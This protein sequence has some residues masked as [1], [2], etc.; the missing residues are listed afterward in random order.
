MLYLNLENR[1][2]K[3]LNKLQKKQFEQV[4]GKIIAMQESPF[5]PDTK[6]IKGMDWYRVD[7]GEF[8]IIFNVHSGV[9]DVPLIGKRNDDEVYKQL[10]RLGG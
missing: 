5:P 3:F 2:Q 1:A 10:K 4:N 9:L 7:I 8:R 6:R